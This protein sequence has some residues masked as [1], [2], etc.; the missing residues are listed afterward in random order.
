MMVGQAIDMGIQKDFNTFSVLLV[1]GAVLF[2]IS[3]LILA[4]IYY[5]S[6]NRKW[7]I[8][9]NL[10]TYYAAQLLIALSI[11]YFL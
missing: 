8:A 1:S 10:A 5:K 7:M 2:A 4:P 11:Y 9:L 3:D 6:D